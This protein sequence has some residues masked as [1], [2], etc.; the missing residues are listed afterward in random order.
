MVQPPRGP[1]A[2]VTPPTPI[3]S[4]TEKSH[5]NNLTRLWS[6]TTERAKTLVENKSRVNIFRG[7]FSYLLG[8]IFGDRA[9]K[10]DRTHRENEYETDV[11]VETVGRTWSGQNPAQGNMHAGGGGPWNLKATAFEVSDTIWTGSSIREAGL[12]EGESR[13]CFLLPTVQ[14][15]SVTLNSKPRPA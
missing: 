5:S 2:R 6:K 10:R 1:G 15:G 13:S 14:P 4:P 7:L 8:L 11:L 3:R 9:I 12:A